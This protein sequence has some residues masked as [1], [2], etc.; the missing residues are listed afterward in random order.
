MSVVYKVTSRTLGEQ[1]DKNKINKKELN[2]L[3]N[4][5]FIKAVI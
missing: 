4:L 3:A 2:T 1:E 5:I